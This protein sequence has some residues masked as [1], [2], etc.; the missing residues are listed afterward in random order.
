MNNGYN[1]QE[2]QSRVAKAAANYMPACPPKY[3]ALMPFAESIATLRR[4]GASYRTITEIL[5]TV[6][7]SVSL[8][9][10]ARYCREKVE[11]RQPRKFK[12]RPYVRA[13]S[14]PLAHPTSEPPVPPPSVP[15]EPAVRSKGPRIADPSNV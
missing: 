1:L 14:A 15:G 13:E 10:V 7:V 2:S 9:T 6:R 5:H 4:K 12:R 3:E 11:Q 8:D